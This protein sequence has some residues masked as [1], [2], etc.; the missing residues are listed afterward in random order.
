MATPRTTFN[1]ASLQVRTVVD[2]F[3]FLSPK[4]TPFLKLISGG[5]DEKPSLNS[6]SKPC[7]SKKF[8]WVEKTD[9]P[10]TSLL[11]E[12][13]D[14]SETG[15][16]VT[17]AD[18]PFFVPGTVFIVDSE[19]FLVTTQGT[20]P[21]ITLAVRGYAGSSAAAHS[22][23]AVVTIL[24]N[25]VL[26][27]ANFAESW[28]KES[29]QPFN[30]VQQL[31]QMISVTDMA[32]AIEEYGADNALEK[33]TAEKTRYMMRLLNRTAFIG[34]RYAGTAA[35]PASMGGLDYFIPAA[36]TTDLLGG[37]LETTHVADAMR[38]IYKTSGADNVPDTIICGPLV[39]D[40][41]SKVFAN[42]DVVTN[43]EQKERRGG[44]LIDYIDTHFGSFDILVDHDCPET[45]LFMV[46]AGNLG[47][48]PMNGMAFHRIPLAQTGPVTR[49]GL[50]GAYTMQVR[51][52]AC[53]AKITNIAQII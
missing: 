16:D 31:A 23:G 8:E 36:N 2:V 53:H 48:G 4:V 19:Y 15:I 24:G 12:D 32:Q 3:D 5:S 14:T 33:E 47:I 39:R 41:I 35:I 45:T 42:S 21:T 44:V 17:T 18:H 20:A 34:L 7:K 1:D 10:F 49:F 28:V 30:Y 25:A 52:T 27:D 50:Y 37:A 9:P 29:T 13:L 38:A 11:A 6:L 26:E 51:G 43:R 46:K 22:T 40:R